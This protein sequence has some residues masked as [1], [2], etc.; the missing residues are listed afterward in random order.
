MHATVLLEKE[1]TETWGNGDAHA[2]WD[3]SLH[4]ADQENKQ[5]G[6]ANEIWIDESV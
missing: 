1:S 3:D 4:E 6:I 5:E 2:C